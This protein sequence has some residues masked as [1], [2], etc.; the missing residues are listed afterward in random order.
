MK[1]QAEMLG[2]LFAASFRVEQRLRPTVNL[3]LQFGTHLAQL[4]VGVHPCD[5]FFGCERLGQVIVGACMEQSAYELAIE[6]IWTCPQTD[7]RRVLPHQ[8]GR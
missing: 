5:Q 6:R 8:H 1:H 2:Q 3:L 4:N 7:P